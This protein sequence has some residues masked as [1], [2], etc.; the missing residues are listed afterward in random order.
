MQPH[1][2]IILNYAM[3]RAG[4]RTARTFARIS[5]NYTQ[6]LQ[7]EWLVDEWHP[8]RN[9]GVRMMAKQ[10]L[11]HEEAFAVEYSGIRTTIILTKFPVL[12][13]SACADAVRQLN[14]DFPNTALFYITQARMTQELL[15]PTSRCLQFALLSCW[16]SAQNFFPFHLKNKEN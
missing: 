1:P 11:K 4:L 6:A 16:N 12:I 14:K 3:H 5:G 10:C 7:S 8:S 9:S 2:Q 13:H 15:F